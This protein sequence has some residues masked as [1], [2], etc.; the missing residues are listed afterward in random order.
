MFK[1]VAQFL[2]RLKRYD[3]ATGR[4]F[5]NPSAPKIEATTC[6][7]DESSMLT[8]DMLVAVV[9]ALP[10]SCRLLLVGDPYQ[11]PPIGAGCPFVDLIEYLERKNNNT[12]VGKL[13]TPRR[14]N[15]HEVACDA[16]AESLARTDVQLAAIFSGRHLP[17]GED[18][19]VV[20]GIAGL[21]DDT[22]KYRRWEN[23][24]DLAELMDEV[25]TEELDSTSQD[26][27]PRFETSIGAEWNDKG[28]LEFDQGCSNRVDRWQILTVN[29]NGLGGSISINRGIKERLRIE[30]LKRAIDS[31]NVPHY[32]GLDAFHKAPWP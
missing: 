30:R 18:E 25:L 26:L 27:V 16:N 8:E 14:Q 12:G 23:A 11:L 4:Y 19:V 7:V 31:N 10:T 3:S 20:N 1:T 15:D 9:D 17:P 32:I 22:V 21:D 2:L 28:Y 5:V 13:D 24:T 6:V 29:R